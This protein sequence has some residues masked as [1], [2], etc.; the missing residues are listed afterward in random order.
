MA[1]T[2]ASG[3]CFSPDDCQN[4]IHQQCRLARARGSFHDYRSCSDRRG[5]IT[6]RLICRFR[7]TFTTH[8]RQYAE[9][10][11]LRRAEFH[12]AVNRPVPHAAR[13]EQYSQASGGWGRNPCPMFSQPARSA[14]AILPALFPFFQEQPFAV[15]SHPPDVVA[16]KRFDFQPHLC[17]ARRAHTGQSSQHPLSNARSGFWS[18]SL[19][20]EPPHQVARPP[21]PVFLA[22]AQPRRWRDHATGSRRDNSGRLLPAVTDIEVPRREFTRFPKFILEER[23]NLRTI[24]AFNIPQKIQA[25]HCSLS[26]SA[27]QARA[28]FPCG[29]ASGR[30]G[31][32]PA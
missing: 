27:K 7:T 21:G 11:D 3:G 18:Y 30:S 23:V 8:L 28:I 31:S 26:N 25:C 2:C 16:A 14:A 17:A 6:F 10:F 13:A 22:I 24:A 29:P 4:A 15:D 1:A 20:C 32:R 5:E 9:R 19:L 12:F